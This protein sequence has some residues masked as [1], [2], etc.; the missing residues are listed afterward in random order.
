MKEPDYKKIYTDILIRKYPEKI[1]ICKGTLSKEVLSFLDVINLNKIIFGIKDSDSVTFNQK[2]RAYNKSTI[3]FILD[4][5]KKNSLNNLQ[6][7]NHFKM[8][9]NTIAKWR[10]N[11]C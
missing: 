10:K 3:S 2:H 8:S 7:A 11:L 5:Q 4:F 1:S 6:L 9:R